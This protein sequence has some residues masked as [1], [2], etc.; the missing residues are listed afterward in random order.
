[1]KCHL[2]SKITTN[3]AKTKVIIGAQKVSFKV[4]V[5]KSARRVKTVGLKAVSQFTALLTTVLTALINRFPSYWLALNQKGNKTEHKSPTERK[6]EQHL[7]VGPTGDFLSAELI[8]SAVLCWLALGFTL[9]LPVSSC[10]I[11]CCTLPAVLHLVTWL[12]GK[13]LYGLLL[14]FV[15]SCLCVWTA[16][17]HAAGR[18]ST[19]CMDHNS[20]LHNKWL[21]VAQTLHIHNSVLAKQ[22][23]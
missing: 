14:F 7:L 16:A 19:Y 8:T 18:L 2:L 11:F 12:F 22:S 17:Q 10:V 1:M 15:G 23:K 9:L 3:G 6:W 13:P 20:C 5:C 21:T 4:E